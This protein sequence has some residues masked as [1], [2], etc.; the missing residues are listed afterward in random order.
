MKFRDGAL[1]EIVM[2]D[3][4]SPPRFRVNGTMPNMPQWY[5][6]FGVQ[7]D[8]KLFMKPEERVTIW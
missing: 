5:A 6:A 3:V 4:H 1:R 8:D 7:P 2:S